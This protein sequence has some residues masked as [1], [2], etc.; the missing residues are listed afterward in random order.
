MTDRDFDF[1]WLGLV[2]GIILIGLVL[3]GLPKQ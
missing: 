2:A 3:Y 1:F